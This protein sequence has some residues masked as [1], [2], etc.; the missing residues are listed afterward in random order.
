[1]FIPT[2]EAHPHVFITPIV[3]VTTN[4]HAVSKINVEWDFD[5]M[6][7]SLYLESCGSDANQIWNILFPPTQ[8]LADGTYASRSGYYTNVEIDGT[9]LTNLTPAYFSASY[10]GG[11]LHTQ[12]TLYINQNVNNKLRIWFD[13]STIYNAFDTEQGNF[14]VAD[15]S[16]TAH[17]LQKQTENDIDKICISF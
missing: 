14:Q 10:V 9:P 15:Q 13:D 4:N 1:L 3:T 16:G 12:F 11:C 2:V 7:S 6:S 17:P 8:L 5:A